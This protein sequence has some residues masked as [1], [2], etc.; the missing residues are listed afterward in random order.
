MKVKL[1]KRDGNKIV[2]EPVD[3]IRLTDCRL[4][5]KT[6]EEGRRVYIGNMT[7]VGRDGME[8]HIV[9]ELHIADGEKEGFLCRTEQSTLCVK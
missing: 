9:A 2:V 7:E 3:G 8:H 1:S 6:D 5:A 4:L